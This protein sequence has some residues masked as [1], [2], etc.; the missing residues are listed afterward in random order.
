MKLVLSRVL[1]KQ[2]LVIMMSPVCIASHTFW[3]WDGQRVGRSESNI[4]EVA[5]SVTYLSSHPDR[6]SEALNAT[7]KYIRNTV[8]ILISQRGI[9]FHLLLPCEQA[10]GL[11]KFLVYIEANKN[12]DT[13]RSRHWLVNGKLGG[14]PVV[15]LHLVCTFLLNSSGLKTF[16]NSH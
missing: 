4:A 3:C 9:C 11:T 7:H 6:T 13:A 5:P 10:E 8:W 14:V 16:Q 12:G 1:D 2:F 15:C